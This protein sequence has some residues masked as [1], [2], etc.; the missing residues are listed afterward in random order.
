MSANGVVPLASKVSAITG[1]A[2]PATKEKLQQ[3][4]GCVNF[5]HRFVPHLASILAPLHELTSSA[6]T[7]KASLV[8]SSSQER[9]FRDAK[10]ALS[11]AVMLAHP[12][13]T[14]EL[15]LTT[16]ALDVA[17]GAVLSQG[18]FSS[19]EPLAFFS[20]KLSAAEKN[21]SAFDKEL[22]AVYLAVRHFRHHL[23]A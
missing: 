9:A 19:P 22:L 13:P 15:H 16:D 11:G 6:A 7:Q 5:Y 21:Y 12:N 4:L 23:E 1:M 2:R 14:A 18:P 17:V 8:W 3:F 10:D 20:K